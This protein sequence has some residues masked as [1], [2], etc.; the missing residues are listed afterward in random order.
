MDSFS[1]NIPYRADKTDF[2]NYAP[3]LKGIEKLE[4]EKAIKNFRIVSSN[5]EQIFNNLVTTQPTAGE[6]KPYLNGF[7]HLDHSKPQQPV[8]V[9]PIIRNQK[10]SEFEII[11]AL[12]KKRYL[13]FKRN[14]KLIL[15]VL[16]LPTIFEIIA[17]GF[18]TLRPPGEHDVN[19]Q[20]SRGLYKNSTELYRFVQQQQQKFAYN[21]SYWNKFD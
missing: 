4:N 9:T 7:S 15:C 12:F 3:L 2:I 13:H 16:V 14:Y 17:M 6:E 5:L 18:M 20:F 8:H 21:F 10:L 1:V 11:K 19:L